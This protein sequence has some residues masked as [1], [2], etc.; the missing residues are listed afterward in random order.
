MRLEPPTTSKPRSLRPRIE[1]DSTQG[2]I[3][4]RSRE[5][6]PILCFR[7]GRESA[8]LKLLVLAGQ[9]GDERTACLLYTSPS[10]RDS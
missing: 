1:L 9:H 4:G 6:R 3:I 2:I 10:P 5:N 8:A 7:R